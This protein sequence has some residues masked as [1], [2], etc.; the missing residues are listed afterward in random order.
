L[1][2]VGAILSFGTSL[3]GGVLVAHERIVVGV[4]HGED[5]D[6]ITKEL[7]WIDSYSY[8][9]ARSDLRIRY[10]RTL[11]ESRPSLLLLDIYL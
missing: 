3:N 8:E 6:E 2:N 10:E 1:K 4:C 9:I 5:F 11:A 7:N